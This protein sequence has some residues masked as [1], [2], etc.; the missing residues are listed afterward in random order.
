MALLACTELSRLLLNIQAFDMRKGT[1]AV[2][3]LRYSFLFK[4]HP[5]IAMHHPKASWDW[6]FSWRNVSR[7][8]S[9]FTFII[10]D[11]LLSP[12]REES[13]VWPTYK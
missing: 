9:T 8:N 11:L 13:H 12:T 5:R 4:A 3:Q 1:R 6:L 7:T 10:S 2:L